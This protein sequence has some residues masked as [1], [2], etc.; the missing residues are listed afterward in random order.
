MEIWMETWMYVWICLCICVCRTY[1]LIQIL[2]VTL[3]KLHI[4]L[5]V[6]Q[7]L[8]AVLVGVFISHCELLLGHV[9]AQDGAALPRE[10]RTDVAVS[11]R[12][13]S[14]VQHAPPFDPERE[15]GPAAVELVEDLLGHVLH[16]L[17]DSGMRAAGGGAG[18]G[19]EVLRG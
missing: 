15:R 8:C 14:Q 1:R 16:G 3:Y 7:L 11:P 12:P 18:R 2:Y 13:T 10:G 9:N 5:R 19:L 6:A 17:D 4:W